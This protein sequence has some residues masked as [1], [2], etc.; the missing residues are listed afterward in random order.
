MYPQAFLEYTINLVKK[1]D[2]TFFEKSGDAINMFCLKSF[3][4]LFTNLTIDKNNKGNLEKS[5]MAYFML[6]LL[7]LLG[8]P[9]KATTL[10]DEQQD[11][12]SQLVVGETIPVLVKTDKK[13]AQDEDVSENRVRI[14]RTS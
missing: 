5:E 4:S 3:Y 8:D 13:K 12:D 14:D 7:F 11:R 1:F 10:L 9:K 2:G 6:D